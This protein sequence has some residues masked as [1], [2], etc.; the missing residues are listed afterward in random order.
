MRGVP[1]PTNVTL[2]E[3]NAALTNHADNTFSSINTAGF[4]FPWSDKGDGTG[5]LFNGNEPIGGSGIDMSGT[6]LSATAYFDLSNF[7]T[8]NWSP[9][10]NG[11]QNGTV[12]VNG[13]AFQ[14]YVMTDPVFKWF[15]ADETEFTG[16]CGNQNLQGTESVG[17]AATAGFM[18]AVSKQWCTKYNIPFQDDET[19]T[20]THFAKMWYDLLIASDD[21]LGITKGKSNPYTWTSGNGCD[22]KLGGSRDPYTNVTTE[23]I[24]THASRDLYFLDEGVAIGAVDRNLLIGGASPPIGEY[25]FTNPLTEVTV[26]QTVYVS[27]TSEQ[28]VDRVKNCNRPSGA[29]NITVKDANEILLRYK[30]A[31][32]SA[33]SAGFD[34]DDEGEVQF[35]GYYDSVGVSGTTDW[36]L[37]DITLANG[38]LMA[39]SIIIIAVIS[40]I[41][42][43]ST[44][45]VESRVLLTLVGVGLVLISFFGALG[46]G[47]ILGIKININIA[48]TLPFIILGLGVDDMYIVL[49][50]IKERKGY[51][52]RDFITAMKEVI[53]PVT[54]T[55]LV[56][57]AM[58]AIMNMVNIPAVYKTAQMALISVIFLYLTIVFCFP[59]W[60]YFDMKRQAAG[61]LDVFCCFKK[62]TN[63]EKETSARQADKD[64]ETLLYKYIYKPLVFGEGKIRWLTHAIILLGGISIF[65]TGIYGLTQRKVGL[66][67]EDFFPD[68]HQAGT[69][70]K[71]RTSEMASWT[72]TVNW[73]ALDYTEPNVQMKMIKQFE[74]VVENS[75]VAELDTK[76]LWMGSFL[77]W[78]TRHCTANFDRDNVDELECGA[79]Q[80]FTDDNNF[81]SSCSGIWTENTFDLREKFIKDP[82]AETCNAYEG[83]ICRSAEDM[84]PL[85]V[86]GTTGSFCPVIEGWSNDKLSFCLTKWRLYTGGGGSL[87]M[88]DN[89]TPN[90][91]CAGEV[92]RDA[93][94]D[95][96]IR[97]SRSPTMYGL[98]LNSHKDT[99]A[100]LE[101]TRSVC[102]E[103]STSRCWMAGIPFDFW[104][105]YIYVDETLLGVGGAS[106]AVGFIVSAIFLF[107]QLKN[108]HQHETSKILAGS[109]AGAALIALT[110]A[111]CL[112]PVVGLSV[113]SNVSFTAF[114]NMSFVLS[115]A[116]AVEHS[117]HVVHRF[118]EAPK[119]IKAASARV[120][121]AMSFLFLPLT[122]S[123]ISSAV[124]VICLAFTEFRFNEVYFFRPLIIV[125]VVTYFFGVWFLPVL[126]TYMNF[127]VLNF[128]KRTTASVFYNDEDIK[129]LG[130]EIEDPEEIEELDSK[131]VEV[132]AE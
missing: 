43:F 81:T 95:A 132:E 39:I 41:F 17:A 90:P 51:T 57:G 93:T 100:M 18:G 75:Y 12:D 91:T 8:S 69:W 28:I 82:K 55:S 102:D 104:E 38:K 30:K 129:E 13:A 29:L 47:L 114:S 115:V 123:F 124:G 116:F 131:K 88:T 70:A 118:L 107:T 78:T 10:Y 9:L 42:L 35:V 113:L 34:N 109:I 37:D 67:L 77:M 110:T 101:G 121:Y 85:D 92:A 84:H 40:A 111:V 65:A 98:H 19:Y 71:T 52:Q 53:V 76:Y 61:R 36:L 45:V 64:T 11:G 20:K 5:Y 73:G 68:D 83:G 58:F 130:M 14:G 72:I 22:Y 66:G 7:G 80:I 86:V 4:P 106:V 21:F 122:L 56:N 6:L 119:G 63:P 46:F 15:I 24:L 112:V 103:D 32:E 117:V 50:S 120:E 87:T 97:Y 74:D 126:L 128:G 16:H 3:A 1:C 48:W 125:M 26:I 59:A 27:I 89:A 23:D 60:C 49:I 105:Q 62:D 25:N 54:M 99:V 127:E 96:P 94:I 33:W 108:E 79:D 31:F 44:D 2:P